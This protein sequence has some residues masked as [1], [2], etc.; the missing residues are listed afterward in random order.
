[1]TEQKRPD[2]EDYE[3][4]CEIHSCTACEG[5][6]EDW[7]E[8]E[9]AESSVHYGKVWVCSHCGGSGIEPGCTYFDEDC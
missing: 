1:M 2:D 3:K 6:G 7:I 8:D 9:W 5:L 4:W